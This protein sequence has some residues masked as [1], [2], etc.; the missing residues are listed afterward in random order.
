[1]TRDRDVAIMFLSKG[2]LLT[3]R[4][5]LGPKRQVRSRYLI[6]NER[7]H[8]PTNPRVQAAS[9]R[10]ENLPLLFKGSSLLLGLPLRLSD[11]PSLHA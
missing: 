9:E 4:G 1:M 7:L 11:L 3:T 2:S 6:G 10:A 8:D 5:P